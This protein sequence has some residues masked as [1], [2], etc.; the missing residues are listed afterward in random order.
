MG[1][2]WGIFSEFFGEKKLQ[3]IISALYFASF[4]APEALNKEVLLEAKQLGFSDKQIAIVIE[5]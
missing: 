1:K 2:L 3:D 5:R 4:Q